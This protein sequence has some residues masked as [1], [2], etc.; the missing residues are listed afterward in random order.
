[1]ALGSGHLLWLNTSPVTRLLGTDVLSTCG[2]RA[3]DRLAVVPWAPAFEVK[4]AHSGKMVHAFADSG[5]T[6]KQLKQVLCAAGV[7]ETQFRLFGRTSEELMDGSTLE[8][9]G[10][11]ADSTLRFVRPRAARR[12]G[13]FQIFVKTLTGKTITLEAASSDT[14]DEVKDLIHDKEGIPPDQERLLLAGRQLE[15]G[16]TLGYYNIQK[17][18]TLTLVLRL[19]GA[20]FHDTSGRIDNRVADLAAAVPTVDVEVTVDGR[21]YRFTV[22]TLAPVAA[23]EDLLHA[24]VGIAA[25]RC[26]R[27]TTALMTRLWTRQRRRRRLPA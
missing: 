26:T 13:C 14:V 6:V 5:V 2:V 8:E 12:S 25:L 27:R 17:D 3:G 9:C 11:K 21:V 16:C 22:D 24:S 23:L 4:A 1:M 19:R 20:M 7:K 10:I 15:D 18:S